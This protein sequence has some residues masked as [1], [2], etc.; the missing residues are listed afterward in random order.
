MNVEAYIESG[1][2]EAVVL[3]VATEQEQREVQ[4]MASIYPEIGQALDQLREGLES[5]AEAAA[6]P[7][8]A[9]LKAAILQEVAQTPQE[10]EE[11][12]TA[13]PV[14]QLQPQ[15][16][17]NTG[18]WA[19]VACLAL[20]VAATAMF[21]SRDSSLSEAEQALADKQQRIEALETEQQQ[22][23][24]KANEEQARADELESQLAE[25]TGPETRKLLLGQTDIGK[26]EIVVFWNGNSGNT[27]VDISDLPE[28]PE[29]Q[30][31][32][33]WAL[34]EGTPVDLGVI[35]KTQATGQTQTMTNIDAPDA[36]AVTI[37]AAGG[38]P[39]PNLEALIAIANL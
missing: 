25:L 7:P 38:K 30:D 2:L 19:A 27:Y 34:V 39:T 28:L 20:L 22:A 17:S 8:P 1:V 29:T 32:Q 15:K 36:F 33:L 10:R 26:G 37:E 9:D 16:T 14:V 11:V 23:A 21:L 6:V 3:G 24:A 12:E 4:C 18:W 31:Y 5:M 35:D 13:A